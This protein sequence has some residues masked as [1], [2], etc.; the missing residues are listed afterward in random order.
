MTQ[1]THCHMH[2]YQLVTSKPALAEQPLTCCAVV[3]LLIILNNNNMRC[4]VGNENEPVCGTYSYYVLLTCELLSPLARKVSI[5]IC[6][7]FHVYI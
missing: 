5:H 7:Y 6:K 2:I 4:K 1:I 3:T